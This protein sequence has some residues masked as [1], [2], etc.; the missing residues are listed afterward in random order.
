MHVSSPRNVATSTR[1]LVLYLPCHNRYVPA[2]LEF[3]LPWTHAALARSSIL[4]Y[5]RSSLE[6]SHLCRFHPVEGR[7]VR[8]VTQEVRPR[9]DPRI[10]LVEPLYTY[11][12]Q[13]CARS[14]SV[15]RILIQGILLEPVQLRT[16]PL[17]VKVVDIVVVE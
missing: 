17:V 16:V 12:H 14:Q 8:P 10:E 7:I 2:Q 4:Q 15:Y 9:I 3:A 5:W 1:L 13:P 11:D 6:K